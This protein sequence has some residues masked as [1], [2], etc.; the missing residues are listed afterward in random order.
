MNRRLGTPHSPSGRWLINFSAFMEPNGSFAVFEKS[1]CF[2]YVEPGIFSLGLDASFIE[3]YRVS[4]KSFPDYKRVL[5]E[6]YVE[7]KHMQL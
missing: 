6:N 4:I 3:I 1:L 2:P 5:Q 7:Y